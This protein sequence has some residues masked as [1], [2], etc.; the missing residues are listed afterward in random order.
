MTLLDL[1]SRAEREL[2]ERDECAVEGSMHFSFSQTPDTTLPK[3][4]SR[5]GSCPRS[6]AAGNTWVKRFWTDWLGGK[7]KTSVG[8]T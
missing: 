7:P 2:S 1:S 8:N 5:Q 4:L 3:D 6:T